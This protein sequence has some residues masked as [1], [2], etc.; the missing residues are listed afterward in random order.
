MI[1]LCKVFRKHVFNDIFTLYCSPDVFTFALLA[2]VT[3]SFLDSCAHIRAMHSG[4]CMRFPND[5]KG[6][7]VENTMKSW[8]NLWRKLQ[9]NHT[10]L[11]AIHADSV[12]CSTKKLSHLMCIYVC[13]YKWHFNHAKLNYVNNLAI[14]AL[15]W[16]TFT[17]SKTSFVRS[18]QSFSDFML[19]RCSKFLTSW[20][21]LSMHIHTNESNPYDENI[22][23]FYMNFFV[24]PLIFTT[25]TIFPT[26]LTHFIYAPTNEIVVR[27]HCYRIQFEFELLFMDFSYIIQCWKTSLVET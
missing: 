9:V 24:K 12:V 21:P 20:K 11:L 16:G 25:F 23:I 5:G 8:R 3:S 17:L 1:L 14:L 27:I 6:L 10:F 19:I 22:I 26:G 13:L 2:F 15:E 4:T 18:L 7:L